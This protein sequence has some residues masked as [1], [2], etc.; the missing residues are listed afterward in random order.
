MIGP[1]VILSW[2]NIKFYS[3]GE[4]KERLNLIFSPYGFMFIFRL[5]LIIPIVIKVTKVFMALG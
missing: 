5:L 1:T 2:N 4:L 3:E